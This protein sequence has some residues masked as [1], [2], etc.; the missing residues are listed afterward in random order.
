MPVYMCRWENGEVS[1]VS[2]KSKKDA[3]FLLDEFAEVEPDDL[4]PVS[5][6]MLSFRLTDDGA[7]EVSEMGEDTQELFNQTI[8]PVLFQAK[9][10]VSGADQV[11]PQVKRR[12]IREAVREEETRLEGMMKRRLSK[13]PVARTLQDDMHMSAAVAERFAKNARAKREQGG[14][15]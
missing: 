10:R 7:L 2:A 1:F 3:C 11:T 15:H 14:A 13:N 5:D 9:M 8:Y 6:F 4:H 12:M